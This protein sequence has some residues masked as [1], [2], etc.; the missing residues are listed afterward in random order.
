MRRM[1]GWESR[2]PR[3]AIYDFY[4]HNGGGWRTR[5]NAGVHKGYYTN[6]SP[7]V[8]RLYHSIIISRAALGGLFSLKPRGEW[9]DLDLE[10]V[11]IES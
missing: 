5:S 1:I 11:M 3:S 10:V 9:I 2:S 4:D 7:T 8:D 6:K